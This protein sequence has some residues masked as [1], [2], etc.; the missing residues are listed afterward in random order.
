MIIPDIEPIFPAQLEEVY[1][2]I[3]QCFQDSSMLESKESSPI[4]PAA[5]KRIRSIDEILTDL[6]RSPARI[7]TLEWRKALYYKAWPK[8]AIENGVLI[9]QSSDTFRQIFF[10]KAIQWLEKGKRPFHP[11][12]ERAAEHMPDEEG[13]GFLTSMRDRASAR[14]YI[15]KKIDKE[16]SSPQEMA[17]KAART[18]FPRSRWDVVAEIYPQILANHIMEDDEEKRRDAISCLFRTMEEAKQEKPDTYLALIENCSSLVAEIASKQPATSYEP[19]F[20]RLVNIIGQLLETR[21]WSKLKF[22]K[23]FKLINAIWKGYLHRHAEETWI[24]S[25]N[26]ITEDS[27]IQRKMGRRANFWK[28]LFSLDI[29]LAFLKRIVFADNDFIRKISSLP[30]HGT[31][32]ILQFNIMPDPYLPLTYGNLFEIE[33]ERGNI[34]YILDFRFGWHPVTEHIW[35]GVIICYGEDAKTCFDGETIS[36]PSLSSLTP[37]FY[38]P[39]VLFWQIALRKKLSALASNAPISRSPEKLKISD[40]SGRE[41]DPAE[42]LSDREAQLKSWYETHT[43]LELALRLAP[44][45]QSD[46]ASAS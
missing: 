6:A 45:A 9:L 39:P 35:N 10:N 41:R 17:S 2:K 27:Q 25:I 23:R 22:S 20:H 44:V 34:F 30:A 28:R 7:S 8:E 37:V 13:I 31:G 18:R 36:F 29:R 24:S 43:R 38:E 19:M 5:I 1:Q 42:K 16:F 46:R 15:S 32:N 26:S 12:L 14:K 3:C 11:L 40:I 4:S 21:E 33:N